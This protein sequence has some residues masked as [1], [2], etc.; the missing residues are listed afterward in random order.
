MDNSRTGVRNIED[1]FG[2]CL[3][4]DELTKSKEVLKKKNPK[5]LN[6]EVASKEHRGHLKELPPAKTGTKEIV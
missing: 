1:E 3:A 6:D 5:P 2:T 4:K